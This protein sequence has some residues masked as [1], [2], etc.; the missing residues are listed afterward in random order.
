MTHNWHRTC[1]SLLLSL[2]RLHCTGWRLENWLLC[3]TRAR[4]RVKSRE[5]EGRTPWW[6]FLQNNENFFITFPSFTTEQKPRSVV[7]LIEKTFINSIQRRGGTFWKYERYFGTASYAIPSSWDCKLHTTRA[8][9]HYLKNQHFSP[10]RYIF[11]FPIRIG[12]ILVKFEFSRH[13]STLFVNIFLA[14]NLFKKG[15]KFKMKSE[16]SFIDEIF[17][18]SK[19]WNRR[20]IGKNLTVC[21]LFLILLI[22]LSKRILR[23]FINSIH[24]RGGTF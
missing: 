3:E 19:L 10:I 18:G 15:A 21:S 22:D 13:F 4:T 23:K 2:L 14:V 16:K 11:E 7:H 1:I 6:D 5:G 20:E 8:S 17:L 12:E 24:R 9:P